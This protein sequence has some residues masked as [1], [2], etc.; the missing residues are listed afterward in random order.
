MF[1]KL[2]MTLAATALAFGAT[3]TAQ[4][5]KQPPYKPSV[6]PQAAGAWGG[7]TM[8]AFI[9]ADGTHAS[10]A[11]LGLR[12]STNPSTGVYTVIFQRVIGTCMYVPSIAQQSSGTTHGFIN[13]VQLAGDNKGLYIETADATGAAANLD[14]SVLVT[15][16]K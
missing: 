14:F 10:D 6:A 3:A 15:C 11:G 16:Y 9:N 7:T 4:D 13:A 2:T 1:Q 5:D 8:W 12:S